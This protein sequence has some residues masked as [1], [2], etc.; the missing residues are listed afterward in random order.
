MAWSRLGES[1]HAD[2]VIREGLLALHYDL[3]SIPRPNVTPSVGPDFMTKSAPRFASVS[4]DSNYFM[5]V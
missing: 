5:S 4:L 2:I 1:K 3:T